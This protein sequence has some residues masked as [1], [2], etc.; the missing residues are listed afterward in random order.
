MSQ[1]EAV[2]K[3]EVE[4]GEDVPVDNL[5]G[6]KILVVFMAVLLLVCIIAFFSVLLI[7]GS[8]KDQLQQTVPQMVLNI[9]DSEKITNMSLTGRDL[10]LQVEGPEGRRILIVNPYTA[11]HKAVIILKQN[12]TI[13]P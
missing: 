6:L 11:D 10:A 9:A 12:G 13:T 2:P 4:A 1:S 5:L 3:A 7:N 8:K